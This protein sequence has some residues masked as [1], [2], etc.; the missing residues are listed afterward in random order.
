MNFDEK[1]IIWLDHFDFLTYK[2]KEKLLSFVSKPSD[3][4][5]YQNLS[6]LKNELKNI[7]SDEDLSILLHECEE[8]DIENI[9]TDIEKL[10]ISMLTIISK[11][12][13]ESL[14]NIS[15]PPF[16]IYY[17]GNVDLLYTD[18]FAVVGTRHL[19]SYG[20]MATEKFTRGLCGVGFTIVSGLA[21]GIDTI[22]HREA[23]NSKGKTIAVLAN[24]LDKIYPPTNTHLAQ[25]IISSGGLIISET[26][27]YRRAESFLFPIRNRIIAGLSRGVLVTE[28][29]EKSGA[30]HTKNYALEFGKDVFS[31]PGSIFNVTSNGT[32][33]LIVN[34]QA[35][36]VVDLD[37]ILCEYNI[38]LSQPNQT[39][40]NVSIEEQIVIDMLSS[41]E[42]TFQELVD[43]SHL[44]VKKLNNILT[45]LTI[46][47]VIKKLAGNVY[48]LN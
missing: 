29:Q 8:K 26:R 43:I 35:K 37:D 42:K 25:E 21:S 2:K 45:M 39:A 44:E 22:A 40:Y 19:T 18:C 4:I 5:G 23:L 48:Y 9:V 38:K 10:G 11:G 24:G 13:P 30:M 6:R 15:T 36:A 28:A 17:K 7:L 34:G 3:L 46:R 41:G 27:P 12:Y 33:R 14:A 20:K 1:A 32:N 47:G 31:V 16:V